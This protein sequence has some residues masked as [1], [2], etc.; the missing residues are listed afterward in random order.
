LANSADYGKEILAS[1]GR[2]LAANL[3]PS[4]LTVYQHKNEL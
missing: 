3:W 4:P 2:E 1:L